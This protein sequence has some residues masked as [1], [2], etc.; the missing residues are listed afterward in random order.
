ML[1]SAIRDKVLTAIYYILFSYLVFV[2]HAWIYVHDWPAGK[3]G[4]TSSTIEEHVV[5]FLPARKVLNQSLSH[6][7]LHVS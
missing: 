5:G 2:Q 1:T 7:P 4:G 6:V 3:S